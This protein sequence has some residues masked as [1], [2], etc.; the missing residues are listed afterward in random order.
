MRAVLRCGEAAPLPPLPRNIVG[1]TIAARW[2]R[3]ARRLYTFA[4]HLASS[5][6][7][8]PPEWFRYPLP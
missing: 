1:A 3:I 7:A 6:R 4:E 2:R 5:P 8:L